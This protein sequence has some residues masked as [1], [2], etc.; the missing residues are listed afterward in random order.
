[1]GRYWLGKLK[2]KVKNS[3]G[4]VIYGAGYIADCFYKDAIKIGVDILYCVVTDKKS[5]IDFNG[6]VVFDFEEKIAD[7]KKYNRQV[8]VV[9]SD[10]YFPEIKKA[11]DKHGVINYFWVEEFRRNILAELKNNYQSVAD[12]LNGMEEWCADEREFEDLETISKLKVIIEKKEK[13]K[14]RILFVICLMSPRVIKIAHALQNNGYEVCIISC[15][16]K[17][18][19]DVRYH[20]FFKQFYCYKCKCFE[21]LMY[22]IIVSRAE[23]IHIFSEYDK[24]STSIAYNLILCK[25]IFSP[26]VFEQYDVANGMYYDMSTDVLGREQYCLENADGV[27][28]RGNELDYLIE[29]KNFEIKGKIIKFFDY[30]GDEVFEGGDQGELSLCY[31]GG[32]TTE[33]EWPDATY[34]CWIELAKICE[35]NKCHLHVYPDLWNEKKFIDYI[36]MENENSYFHFHKPVAYCDLVKELSQYDYGIVPTKK[37]FLHK[38]E[39]G[40]VSHQKMIYAATN[41]IYDDLAAGLPII[42]SYPTLSVKYFESKGVALNWTIEEIDF[43][44]LRKRK[45]ELKKRVKDIRKKWQMKHKIIELIRFYDELN[46]RGQE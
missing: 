12:C 23:I 3:N 40:G 14:N 28:C 34:A 20:H 41:K 44:Q 25:K 17:E 4:I 9:S 15:T 39:N 2:D 16:D 35:K 29:E 38:K 27:C 10:L 46:I 30:I 18:T 32:I 42:F 36:Y 26:I 8:V 19:E 7:I 43:E 31:A 45:R 33:K 13:I 21:E 22:R 1:M 24:T 6:I 37:G 11:L 5:K